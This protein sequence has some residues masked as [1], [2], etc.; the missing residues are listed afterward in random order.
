MN[1]FPLRFHLP[2]LITDKGVNVVPI[3]DAFAKVTEAGNWP[4]EMDRPFAVLSRCKKMLVWYLEQFEVS[5]RFYREHPNCGETAVPLSSFD[6][7]IAPKGLHPESVLCMPW[8]EPLLITE[9]NQG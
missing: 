8:Y 1:K 6:A 7:V 5:E 2:T 9:T 4:K 3:A